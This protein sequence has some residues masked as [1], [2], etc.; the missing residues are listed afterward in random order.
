MIRVLQFW[1]VQLALQCESFPAE[2]WT[3]QQ[4]R[5]LP[6]LP[7]DRHQTWIDSLRWVLE[8]LLAKFRR[9]FL[10]IDGLERLKERG[11]VKEMIVMVQDVLEQALG[12]VSIATFSRP[13][14]SLEPLFQLADVSIKLTQF[15]PDL[16]EY[17]RRKVG[18]KVKPILATAG[19]DHD[20]DSI[21]AMEKVMASASAGL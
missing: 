17:I 14:S 6:P 21:A 5:D 20:D 15:E 12:D 1:I 9:T 8:S 13:L 19:L 4:I 2:S 7:H 16:S 3:I 10:L 18:Q 11:A